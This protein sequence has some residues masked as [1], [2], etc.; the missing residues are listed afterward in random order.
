[1]SQAAD[2]ERMGVFYLGRRYDLDRKEAGG[3]GAS[4]LSDEAF[5]YES[6][7][8]LTH[9]LC[10]GMTGSGKTGLCLSLLEEAAIDGI[11]AIV[12]DPKG[13]LSNLLLAFP[14][15]R[16]SDFR[17]FIDEG[18]AER[19][20]KSADALAVEV[21]QKWSE[22]LAAWGQDGARVA[23]FKDACDVVVYTPGSAAGVQLALLASFDAPPEAVREDAEA[24]AGMIE[25]A[26]SG[27]LALAGA[28]S[29]LRGRE[30][31]LVSQLL[32][33]AW[34]EGKS[35]DLAT[36]VQSVQKPPFERVGALDLESFFPAKDRAELAM[37]LNALL[38]S[39]A[40]SAWAKGAP[41]DVSSLLRS[42]N[43]K[44]RI[45]VVSIAHLS[46]EQRMFFVTKL[47]G[48]VV[49]WMR[50]QSGTTSLRAIV[51]MD[52]IFGYFPPTAE[53][54]SKRPMLTLLK[55][56]RAFGV[57]VVLATQNP[58]D[59]DY[60]GLANCGTW[61]LGRLQAERDKLRVLDGLESAR[62]SAPG[63]GATDRASLD[64][65]LSAL[66][67]RVFLCHD[68]HAPE[69]V[70]FQSRHTLSYLR[71]PLTREQIASLMA[72]RKAQKAGSASSESA[73]G[74]SQAARA[75]GSA[76]GALVDA[77]PAVG[78]DVEEV[79]FAAQ[80]RPGQSGPVVYRAG[81]LAT[82][83]LHYV[84]AKAD[85]DTWQTLALVAPF[86]GGDANW[87]HSTTLAPA[88][89]AAAGREP[90][91]G[92]R[93]ETPP[94]LSAKKL[95]T[96]KKQLTTHL[97]KNASLVLFENR[98]LSLRS[99]PGE[100]LAD[101]R[102]R[103]A[104]AAREDR[105]RAIAELDAKYKPKFEALAEK[106]RRAQ[107]KIEKERSDVQNQRVGTAVSIGTGVLGAVFGRGVLTGAN[108]GR[109]GSVVRSA[110]RVAKEEE[111]VARAVAD[112]AALR[113][114]W[115]ELQTEANAELAALRDS[116]ASNAGTAD[117]SVSELRVP[118]KKTDTS[119]DRFVVAWVPFRA[120]ASGALEPAW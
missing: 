54:P 55:Q 93:Y 120:S 91:P 11:P 60:K 9:A 117:A 80:P 62:A 15:Q 115:T 24:L 32:A 92:A 97:T 38:A 28:P 61:F 33:G 6:K 48:A 21:A 30:H 100:S 13:D 69:P 57:G 88:F 89:A 22:G 96:W 52:E 27:L 81:V 12:I 10:V 29:E 67:A 66:G 19:R 107:T 76:A 5:L 4:L 68:V 59:L 63:A 83:Q 105:D 98:A 82:M 31:V 39:P 7:H 20:G 86:D 84:L 40:A 43:G 85:V 108:V 113:Q 101:F 99:R 106:L 2:F 56:A 18:E 103:T 111:D 8:L 16:P 71:G 75:L 45:A 87:E 102:G 42:E 34:A 17:P 73:T 90:E 119:I 112:D 114:K 64:K 50:L 36:L 41:L 72:E 23:R 79:F 51:Y 47:L 14:E 109:A 53:P 70:I 116:A 94:A 110:Q 58:V 77:R 118:P 3:L 78:A 25:G 37:T 44:P 26:T 49:A 1:M 46:D 95:A 74:T 35:V 65:L 104:H